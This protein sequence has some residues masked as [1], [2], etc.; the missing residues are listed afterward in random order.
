MGLP[1]SFIS[2]KR[3]YL[4]TGT[5]NRY[6]FKK[7]LFMC[8]AACTSLTLLVL[9]SMLFGN[10]GMFAEHNTD[11]YTIARY[12]LF[13]LPQM[14]YWVLPFSICV[15]IIATQASFAR[16]AETIAMQAS[17][18][19]FYRLVFPYLQVG[20]ISVLIM[21]FFSFY[22]YPV[23]Q[24]QADRLESIYIKKKDVT[25]S[26]S[27]NGGRFKVG[28]DIFYLDHLDISKGIM[29]HVNCYRIVAGRLVS[30]IRAGSA[31]WD[32]RIWK[33]RDMELIKLSTTGI[34]LERSANALP[35]NRG[36]ADL[37]TAQ[38][39]PEDLTLKELFEYRSYLKEEDIQSVSLDTNFFSRI[40]FAISPFIMTLLVLPFG[41][42]FPRTGGIARGI[43]IGI[44]L[45]LSYWA[46]HSTMTGIGI[47]GYIHPIAAACTADAVA[48]TAGI[49]LLVKRRGTY[50]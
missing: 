21:G 41:M 49:I 20:L 34:Q 35:L 4:I 31:V 37:V 48:M 9:L 33:T 13:S 12:M 47:S 7:A 25:G 45:G 5:L 24:R 18:I 50:G 23:S 14:V 38:P 6:L 40:S 15:G 42:R 32:G 43:S 8:S 10:L 11:L 3:R 29:H 36:P 44:I 16:H 28:E 22:L 26:F 30:I 17:S 1:E 39:A 19:P 27:V 46:L 2:R